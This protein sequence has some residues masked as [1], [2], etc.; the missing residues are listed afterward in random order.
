MR[1]GLE[2]REG[3]MACGEGEGVVEEVTFFHFPP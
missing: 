3:A 2:G 1:G